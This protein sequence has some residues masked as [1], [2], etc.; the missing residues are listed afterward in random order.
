VSRLLRG[1]EKVFEGGRSGSSW[2]REIVRIWDE[3]EGLGGGWFGDCARRKVGDGV[4]TFFWTDSW[5]DESPLCV[6]FRSLFGLTVNKTC[7]VA[8][9]SSLRWEAGGEA[10]V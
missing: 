3:V 9:M 1:G 8:E 6:K 4:D 5:L 7:T 10:W 2:W